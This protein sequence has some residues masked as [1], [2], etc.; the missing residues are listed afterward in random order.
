M[1]MMNP[2]MN[3]AAFTRLAALSIMGLACI[4]LS[5]GAQAQPVTGAE[6]TTLTR[7][8]APPIKASLRC[9]SCPLKSP[10][11][12]EQLVTFT[13][14]VQLTH[15]A[16]VPLSI[17]TLSLPKGWRLTRPLPERIIAQRQRHE[18]SFEVSVEEGLSAT[19]AE[20]ELALS[21]LYRSEVSGVHS[22]VKLSA[23]A[24]FEEPSSQAKPPRRRALRPRLNL[25]L[26]GTLV[27]P[28]GGVK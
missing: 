3:R 13:L 2:M 10:L 6:H 18:L 26:P 4:N 25:P 21:L 22:K 27:P 14:S 19:S 28:K 24:L 20:G 23:S 1:S 16:Q 12:Q 17:S 11:E 15:P 9:V 7:L 8:A 5:Q